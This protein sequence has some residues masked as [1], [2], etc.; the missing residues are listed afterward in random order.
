MGELLPSMHTAL[1]FDPSI[2]IKEKVVTTGTISEPG[3]QAL[4]GGNMNCL[5]NLV[6]E[7][8]VEGDGDMP[9]SVNK[10]SHTYLSW[11]FYRSVPRLLG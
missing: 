4:P 1:G 11:A 2:I 7:Q 8:K 5:Q 6:V 9:V 3:S 10:G